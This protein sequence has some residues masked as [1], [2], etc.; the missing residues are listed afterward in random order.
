MHSRVR[1][2]T[3]GPNVDPSSCYQTPTERYVWYLVILHM[4]KHTSEKHGFAVPLR[5][6]ETVHGGVKMLLGWSKL[7]S[8]K[9]IWMKHLSQQPENNY[10]HC[11]IHTKIY[12][13]IQPLTVCWCFDSVGKM[14]VSHGNIKDYPIGSP[15]NIAHTNPTAWPCDIVCK[16][17]WFPS[18]VWQ[19]IVET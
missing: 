19:Q 5:I 18:I 2:A 10:K 11:E 15:P 6:C 12:S 16:H 17:S 8:E 1:L 9:K 3:C 14:M 13:M 7:T 4:V